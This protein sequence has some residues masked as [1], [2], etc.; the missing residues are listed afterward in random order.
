VERFRREVQAAAQ[1]LH[2]NIVTAYDAEQAGGLH[3]L[4]M[5]FV[6]GQNLADVLKKQGPLPAAQG[7]C[8]TGHRGAVPADRGEGTAPGDRGFP[9]LSRLFR[10]NLP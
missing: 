6:P 5:E 8:P 4:V 2:P 7:R 3:M 1:L 9:P 10:P